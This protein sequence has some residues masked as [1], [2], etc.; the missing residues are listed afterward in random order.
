MEDYKGAFHDRLADT[1]VLMEATPSRKNA[2]LHMGGVTIECQLK[3][4]IVSVH[5][6]ANWQTSTNGETH[7]ITNPGHELSAAIKRIAKLH[8]RV[9]SSPEVVKWLS[10]VQSLGMSYIDRRYC[11]VDLSP[12]EYQRW[13][14]AY[15]SLLRWLQKQSTQL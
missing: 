8:T 15:S 5:R 13:R 1:K 7:G 10:D 4:L 12:P 2:A 6:I 9:T 3:A 14:T 11:S